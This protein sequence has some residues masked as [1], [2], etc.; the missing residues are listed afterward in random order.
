MDLDGALALSDAELVSFVGAGGKKTAMRWLVDAADR[1][2]LDAGYTTTTHT[3]PPGYTLVLSDPDGLHPALADVDPPV[4]F[5]RERVPNPDRADE[6]VR[7]FAPGVV[8]DVHDAG[9]FDWLLVKADGARRRPFKAPGPDEPAIPPG[10]TVVVVVA[11]VGVVGEPLDER[12]AHRVDRVADVT[13]LEPGDPVTAEAVGTVLAHE[14]GGRKGVP[15]DARVVPMVNQADDE[16]GRE[17]AREV[18]AAAFE[19]TDRFER[20]LVTSFESDRCEV[21]R[22]EGDTTRRN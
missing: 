14:R 19:R 22:P 3:P 13:G 17:Q 1:R 8:D 6:K 10:S 7:G 16:R 5:A 2:D 12:V 18:L 11:S 9:V 21:V 15:D 4:T 20:G